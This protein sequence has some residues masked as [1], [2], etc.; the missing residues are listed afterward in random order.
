MKWGLLA[1][2][3]TLIVTGPIMQWS[4]GQPIDV[5][6]AVSI[7]SPLPEM[8]GLGE[9]LEEIHEIASQAIVPLLALHVLGAL[10]HLIFN[11]DGVFQRILWAKEG[12]TETNLER[13]PGG[14]V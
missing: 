8:R 4:T 11:R 14:T 13:E 5:F 7:P 3:A 1:I 9:A 6:G 12:R 10:K 2:I